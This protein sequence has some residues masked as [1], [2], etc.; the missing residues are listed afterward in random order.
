M[1]RWRA[2]KGLRVSHVQKDLF[3]ELEST[4]PSDLRVGW[5]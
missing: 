5:T 2:P 4:N 3:I 1:S